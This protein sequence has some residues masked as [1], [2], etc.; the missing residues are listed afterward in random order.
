MIYDILWHIYFFYRFFSMRADRLISLMLLL[1]ERGMVSASQLARELEVSAR[2]IFRDIDSLCAAGIPIYAE[3]GSKGGYALMDSYHT[4]LTGLN[5]EELASLFLLD[6]SPSISSLGLNRNLDSAL[7]KISSVLPTVTRDRISWFQQRILIDTAGNEIR[8][9]SGR[10]LPDLAG[11][12]RAIFRSRRLK[13]GLQWPRAGQSGTYVASP[14]GLVG[15]AEDWYLVAQ[16]DDFVRVYPLTIVSEVTE[17]DETF[18]RP[19]SFDLPAFWSRWKRVIMERKSG[20]A[21]DVEIS[22]AIASALD[23]LVRESV[24]EM[25]RSLPHTQNGKVRLEV[26]FPDFTTA[27]S[28]ALG[29]GGAVIVVRP[30]ELVLSVCDYAR[31]TLR[32]YPAVQASHDGFPGGG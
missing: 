12:Q 27:R 7:R 2:T 13:I 23:A 30:R 20:F 4:D 28:F 29:H 8:S 17:L 24:V 3:Q 26:T 21:A 19:D 31:Q 11:I 15:D 6:G 10:R 14:L 9:G 25:V 18:R 5:A 1:Q 22:L 32:Q 16:I